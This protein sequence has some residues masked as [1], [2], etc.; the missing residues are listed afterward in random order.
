MIDWTQSMQQTFEYYVVDPK[1]WK[2]VKKLNNITTSEIT[3]DKTTDTLGS[4]SITTTESIE[5]CYIRIYLVAIQNGLTDKRSLGTFLVQTPS[6]SFDGKV[7]SVTLDA[8]TPLIELKEKNPPLGYSLLEGDNVM[9][10]AS[11]ITRENLRA[12]VVSS[13][14]NTKLFKDFV[15]QPDDTW[16]AFIKDLIANDKK[17]FTLD[18]IGRVMFAP[19]QNIESLQPVWTFN[20]DNSSILYPELTIK[21]DIYKIPNVVE[22]IYSQGEDYFYAKVVNDDEN[23]VLSTVRRGREI[24]RRVT[25]PDITGEATELQVQEYARLLLESLSAV[26]YTISFKHSYCPVR[27]GDCVRL[28]YKRAGINDVKAQITS[29]NISCKSGCTVNATAVFTSKLWGGKL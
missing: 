26:E 12:P 18:E 28:N 20:D 21:H 7:H 4:A 8:Y 9:D 16:L 11:N 6:S 25:N 2:D 10:R 13:V 22:V 24:V 27:L 29:Q 14:S 5:E 19:K 17:E 3:Y 15:S 23:S 1:T